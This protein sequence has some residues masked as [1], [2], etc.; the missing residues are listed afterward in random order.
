MK[1]R[2]IGV[3]ILSLALTLFGFVAV[4][5][6]QSFRS[7]DSSTIKRDEVID[8]SAFVS[9]SNVDV[10]GTID[11]DLYCAGQDV[12]ISGDVSGDILCAAQ[13]IRF[14]GTATGSV[15][16]AAQIITLGGSVGGGAS[17]AGQTITVESQGSVERDATF[18]SQNVTIRGRIARDAVI[19]ASSFILDS[20]VGRNV[21]VN[22]NEIKLETGATVGGDFNYTS[23]HLFSKAEEAT[24]SGE[25]TYNESEQ[26]DT[27]NISAFNP[28]WMIL[29]ALMLIASAVIFALLFP[30][31]LF[32]VGRVSIGSPSK[33]FIALLIGFVA[34]VAVPFIALLFMVTIVGIPFAF[35]VLIG[36][37]LIVAMSGVFAAYYVGRLVWRNQSNN[38][39]LAT[40]VGSVIIALL[41]MIPFFNIFITIL[42]VSYGSGVLLMYLRNHF[43]QPTYDIPLDRP[44]G[45]TA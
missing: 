9:G 20:S 45:K 16:L 44:R 19:G 39:I 32:R 7:G 1:K 15:R 5:N 41:M 28:L 30:R 27:P 38:I 8:G 4:T 17:I 36:W 21:T 14:T 6:A 24:I 22:A 29:W 10:A 31:V 12:T 23:P 26:K 11:G 3:A 18:A 2:L 43:E 35:L 25:I 40:F 13:T 34:V 42:G 37:T 33:A